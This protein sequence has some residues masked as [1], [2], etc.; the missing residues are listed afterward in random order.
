MEESQANEATN[1]ATSNINN[2]T[3]IDNSVNA[4]K[5]ELNIKGTMFGESSLPEE[6]FGEDKS[7]NKEKIE[8]LYKN[9]NSEK[10]RA[11]GLRK[12]LS[13]GKE[14][15]P[16]SVEGYTVEMPEGLTLDEKDPAVSALKQ[17]CLDNNVGNDVFKSILGGVVDALNK[18]GA[19]DNNEESSE[20]AREETLKQEKE[21]LGPDASK[22]LYG[23]EN[24]AKQMYKS[25]VYTK[26]EAEALLSL[27]STAD[28]AMA[29]HKLIIKTGEQPL[30]TRGYVEGLPSKE[31]FNSMITAKDSNGNFKMST[32]SAYYNKVEGIRQKLAKEGVL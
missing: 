13:V 18:S 4:N 27:A 22:I 32:D 29:L 31:E 12:K 16:D 14:S 21:K 23:I 28:E 8:E 9:Y 20:K 2:E 25:G 7:L 17:A 6:Y 10:S 26:A 24:T 19:F 1:V 5:D 15:A 30:P 3:I 11:D